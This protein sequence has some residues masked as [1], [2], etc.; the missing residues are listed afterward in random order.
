M[1]NGEKL[2]LEASG[3]CTIEAI[4]SPSAT[5]HCQHGDIKIDLLKGYLEATAEEGNITVN[6]V[7]GGF[8]LAAPHGQV[9]VQVN[10]LLTP[11]NQAIAG[12]DLNII[13]DPEVYSMFPYLF[14]IQSWL[15]ALLVVKV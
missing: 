7:D 11:D 3:G 2:S 9:D 5:V 4:Y 15:V 6:K 14:A 1:I 13:V 8:A 12:H 10:K